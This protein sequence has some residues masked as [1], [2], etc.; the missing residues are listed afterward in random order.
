MKKKIKK[1][2]TNLRFNILI[3]I[4]YIIGVILII[5][6][7]EL[8]II[9]GAQYR[10]ISNTRLSRE[11]ILEASRG[12]ILDRSGN[13]LA[14]TTST[15][16]LELYKTKS[17]DETL[18]KCIFNLIELFENYKV[19]YPNNF[20]INNECTGFTIEGEE[21]TKWLNKYKLDE[22]TTPEEVMQYFIKKYNINSNSIQEARKIISIRYE[23]TTKGYSSTKSLELAEDVSRD[24]IA[25]I[26]ERNSD[27]PGVTITTQS[28]RKYNY[29]SLASHI[30][31][32]IG[33]ISE[34]EYNAA[35]DIYNNDDYVGRTGIESLFEDYLRGKKRKRR[36]RNVSRWNR[37]GRNYNKRTRA[38]I[39]SS[40]NNRFKTTGSCR[41]SIK[42]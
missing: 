29:N 12:E 5:K 34:K 23:I 4:V 30:I 37:N 3:T 33:K 24:V 6:L 8:Q 17:D 42:K 38:R 1:E 36:N 22:K 13:I 41:N 15:F 16:N 28:S 32:Y 14:T 18:N 9:K 31:G 40:I 20:P 27:F 11:S 2:Y 39:H 35:Q 26:S 21:L 25:Q 7:F 10:E 19:S